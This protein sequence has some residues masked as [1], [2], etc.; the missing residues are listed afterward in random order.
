MSLAVR[1]LM[2]CAFVG[3]SSGAALADMGEVS[4]YNWTQND[5]PVLVLPGNLCTFEGKHAPVSVLAGKTVSL[6][7][8]A[9]LDQNASP[10]TLFVVER[11]SDSTSLCSVRWDDDGIFAVDAGLVCR[12]GETSAADITVFAH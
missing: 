8:D 1:W 7:C 12:Y 11:V 3:A 9:V 4:V 10:V 5:T 6:D 2:V